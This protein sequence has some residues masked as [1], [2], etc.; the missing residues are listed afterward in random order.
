MLIRFLVFRQFLARIN[1]LQAG[2]PL[3]F[4]VYSQLA[5]YALIPRKPNLNGPLIFRENIQTDDKLRVST[6]Q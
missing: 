2:D 1:T 4:G 6:V 5:Q 3:T